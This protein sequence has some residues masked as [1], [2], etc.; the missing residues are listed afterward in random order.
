[1]AVWWGKREGSVHQIAGVLEILL[2]DWIQLIL[3]SPEPVSERPCNIKTVHRHYA[4]NIIID[5]SPAPL[6]TVRTLA[7]E[8]AGQS[9]QSVP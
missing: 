1:M 6:F 2:N 3:R 4:C 7:R 5:K 9:H 8:P